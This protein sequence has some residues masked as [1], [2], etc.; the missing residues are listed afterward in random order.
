M[1]IN[2]NTD[3]AGISKL[4]R[5][6]YFISAL[7]AMTSYSFA[8][9]WGAYS[10]VPVSAQAMV[11]EA[12]GAGTDEGTVVSIG[13]PA[14]T[15]NQ[16]WVIAPKGDNLFSIKPS[17]SSTLVLA[18]AKGEAKN[19][20]PIVLETDSGQ[21]W[22]LWSLTKQ[23][24]GSYS[25]APKHAPEMGLDDQGGKQTP[26]TK[27]DLWQNSGKDQ[28]LQWM[29]KPLAGSTVPAATADAGVAKYEPP[30]IK[31]E[32]V[33]PGVT[34]QFTF[35]QSTVFPGTVRD[36]TVFIPAQYDGSKPACV[37]VKTDGYNPREKT[38]M[39]TMIATK[40][41]PVTIG[42]F[43]RPGDLPS[44][45][46]G[47]IG[48]RN[49]DFEYDGV[50]DNNV[51][52]LVDELLPFV[53]KEYNLKLS[54]DGNDRCM[55]GGSSGGI[56]A[57]TAAWHRPEAFSRVYAASGSW[58]A[59][60]GGHEFPTIVRKFEARPI[61][62]YL[63]TATHDMENCAGDWF[64]LDQEMDKALKFSG[65]DYQ[66]RIIDGRHVAGY[67][68]NW[69]EAMA[70]L[71]RGWPER[72]KAGPSAPRAQDVLLPDESWQLLAEGFKSTRGPA[73]NASG[74][75]F[76]ADTTNNKIHRIALDGSVKEFVA[77]A[78]SA[79]GLTVGADGKLYAVSE[80]T[81]KLMSYDSA[82]VGSIVLDGL[83][84]Q[85]ILARPDGGLYVTSNGDKS[86]A[87]SVWFVK[88]GKKTLVDSGLKFATGL[89]YRPDQWLL[90]VADGHSKWAYS[91]QINADGTL[92]NK[93]R[94]FHLHVADWEDDAG[95][96]S[97]CYA[98]EGQMFVATRSG[99]QICAD[100]GPT[101]V[102]L[103]VPDRSR[104]I[105]VCLGGKDLDTLF[106]FCGDKIWKRK[107]K[108]HAMGAFTPWTKVN[109]T[110]L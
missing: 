90:S 41:M 29:I 8:E 97:V 48:R 67:M 14:G 23:D 16:K 26:G 44:P 12:V 24:N 82:G 65:Y 27:I 35:T 31:P 52:F 93:E 66:F 69:Q 47:T 33:L 55:S 9:D 50:S 99:V 76:F 75:V 74:E 51:R 4:S 36:V 77:D 46:K 105:G 108:S 54:T 34:K 37:Y 102:I 43:V 78:G 96:E 68:D 28:H 86:E 91:Y 72:V 1:K 59:F 57:F 61:R 88:D 81:D 21:P 58:V 89:A 84:G 106:A 101:Q 13:K 22:Q 109:G 3:L 20:S 85:S 10:L 15:A 95:A 2:R 45:V 62:A 19:G 60:R 79:H 11:L 92:T 6:I 53:A 39:E 32:D 70:Y 49:R 71:W 100:D 104:V 103:P 107:V 87:G 40:E 73:C 25:L 5:V 94:F 80:K 63:T 83:R 98:L 38:L 17:S 56:A 110:K 18:V 7:G 30:V 42:V 64:L